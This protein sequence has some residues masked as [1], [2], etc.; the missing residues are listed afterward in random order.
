MA[1]KQNDENAHAPGLAA[2]QKVGELLTKL[3]LDGCLVLN[4]VPF[5]PHD[6]AIGKNA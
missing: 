3:L 2:E 1:G 5:P 4:D 6:F